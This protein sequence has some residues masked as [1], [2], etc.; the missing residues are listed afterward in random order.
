MPPVTAVEKLFV[1]QPANIPSLTWITGKIQQILLQNKER[2]YVVGVNDGTKTVFA[3]FGD[4]YTGHS[5]VLTA[6]NPMYALIQQAYFQNQSVELGV[7]DFGFD[8]QAGIERIII[9]RVT[10]HHP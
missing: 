3:R 6:D 4:P 9:D 2:F 7:R 1:P 10:L 8:A 5:D